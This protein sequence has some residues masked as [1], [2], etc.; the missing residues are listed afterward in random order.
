[1]RFANYNAFNGLLEEEVTA[2]LETSDHRYIFG[3]NNGLTIYKN[4]EFKTLRFS[5]SNN[6]YLRVMGIVEDNSGNIWFASQRIGI[7]TATTRK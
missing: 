5:N 6:Y 1:M 3:H 7:G 2:L 4:G